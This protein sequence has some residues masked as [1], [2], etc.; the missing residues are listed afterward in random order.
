MCGILLLKPKEQFS[1]QE[2]SKLLSQLRHRGPDRESIK[3]LPSFWLGTAQLSIVGSDPLPIQYQNIIVTGNAE[4]YNYKELWNSFS[5]DLN[6]QPYY[7]D[8]QVVIKLFSVFCAQ[9]LSEIDAFQKVLRL[10]RGVYSLILISNSHEIFVARDLL[11]IRPLFFAQSELGYGI[12]SEKE[13]LIEA[14]F[15]LKDVEDIPPGTCLNLVQPSNQDIKVSINQS[16]YSPQSLP[17]FVQSKVDLDSYIDIIQ[18]LLEESIKIRIPSQ[19]F[20]LFFSGG[21]DSTILLTFLQQCVGKNQVRPIAVGYENSPDL[22][23]ARK[24]C[25]LM[26]IELDEII[27]NNELLD[28][29]LPLVMKTLHT[30]NPT[31]MDI[32][33][34]LP[35]FSAAQRARDLGF[36]V[37]LTGQGADEVFFGYQK[38]FNHTLPDNPQKMYEMRQQDITNIAIQNIHRDDKIAMFHSIELRFPFL[39]LKFLG[40]ILKVPVHLHYTQDNR[41]EILRKIATRY[42]LPIEIINRKKKALQY[43]TQTIKY[44]KSQI[45]SRFS[46]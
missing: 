22:L 11:G 38:Y 5:S 24:F 3:E 37:C 13:P 45:Q 42:Q 15:S 29:N 43:G 35:I 2:V 32:S 41:K 10:I 26:K 1:Y 14:G 28:K 23:A 19:P 25:Q 4:I 39:D 36:K 27:L 8:L 16:N 20:G 6:W 21:I 9:G 46:S 30:L 34:A 33:I 17:T 12:C 18:D 44:F 7:N 40:Y 31:P